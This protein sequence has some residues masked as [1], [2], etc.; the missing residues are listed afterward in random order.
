MEDVIGYI[1]NTDS[2][3]WLRLETWVIPA[4][5]TVHILALATLV[6]S[7]LLLDLRL[8]GVLARV[9]SG[10]A[11]V[12][13]YMPTLWV[14]LAIL[15]AS[16]STLMWAEP[17]RVLSKQIFWIKM[18]LVLTGFG[19]TFLL[20][21]KLVKHDADGT[22]G[23]FDAAFGWIALAIWVAALFLGRWIAYAY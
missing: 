19:L 10:A 16:G 4:V 8:A 17:E 15:L 6:G 3:G 14:A 9:D 7:A 11:L 20:R 23:M 5:Q 12:R 2:S 18:A 1:Y 21:S 22:R 13:R